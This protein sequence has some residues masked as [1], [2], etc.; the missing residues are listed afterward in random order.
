MKSVYRTMLI[1]AILAVF[2]IAGCAIT[3]PS[4][5]DTTA[6][7]ESLL[8]DLSRQY[9]LRL[10][11]L[12]DIAMVL[13][14][15]AIKQGAYSAADAKKVLADFRAAVQLDISGSDIK[16]MVLKYV[17]DYPELILL[18]PYLGYLETPR[19]IQPRDKAMLTKWID[20]QIA[21]IR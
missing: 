20:E 17:Y 15:R 1:S 18:S 4:V 2:A 5:C 8:C 12:G 21:F 3:P 10:E 16:G 13:N 9:N 19:I 14:L 7:G 11:T 6:P